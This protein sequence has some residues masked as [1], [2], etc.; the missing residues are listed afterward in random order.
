MQEYKDID[1][2]SLISDGPDTINKNF[3]TLMSNNAGGEFPT[4]NLYAG[5][6]CY[7]SDEGKIYTLK[8]DLSTWVEL[9][10]ISGASGAV[11]PLA[12]ALTK[13]LSIANGGTGATTASQAC[14]NIGAV[15]NT[16]DTITGTLKI[17][18]ATNWANIVL[19]SSLDYYRAV[20]VDDQRLR[21]DIRNTDSTDNRRCLDI[22]NSSQ[23]KTPNN[24]IQLVDYIDGTP[25]VYTVFSSANTIPIANGGTG[26]TT[27][28]NARKNLGTN[29]KTYYTL[30]QLGLSNTATEI[31]IAKALPSNSFI[32]FAGNNNIYTGLFATQQL[33]INYFRMKI[34]NMGGSYMID[35]QDSIGS[36]RYT[37]SFNSSDTSITYYKIATGIAAPDYNSPVTIS[38][39]TSN[40]MSND[41]YLIT[42]VHRQANG[43]GYIRLTINSFTIELDSNSYSYDYMLF[44]VRKGDVVSYVTN[45]LNSY[46]VKFF[47]AR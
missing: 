39:G 22:F 8:N 36:L 34:Y 4:Y 3:K 46:Y 45:G 12:G 1:I 27:A 14:A 30:S 25:N 42:M 26:A 19:N 16:G 2:D 17:D 44:P 24:S 11:A 37:T 28:E 41:G 21:L 9:F 15:K 10:D 31:E 38:A 33:S 32:Y 23:G 13:T 5:M 18:K 29:I 35:L 6:T 20:E 40:I 47:K 43:I 7:R